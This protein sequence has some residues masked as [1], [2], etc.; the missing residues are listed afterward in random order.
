MN[1]RHLRIFVA[2]CETGSFTR[3]ATRLQMSQPALSKIV[4]DLEEQYSLRLFTRTGRGVRLTEG[5]QL[6]HKRATA[7]LREFDLLEEELLKVQDE[8]VGDVN[9]SIPHRVGR[10]I[11]LPL[12]KRFTARF[13]RASIHVFENLNIDTQHMIVCG[14]VDIG[15]FYL[16]PK[17]PSVAVEKI[18]AEHLYVVGAADIIGENNPITMAEASRLPLILPGARAHYRGFINNAF[19]AASYVPNVVRELE[20]V[21][22]LL[23]FAMEGEGATILPYSNIREE[24]ESKLMNARRLI[25]PAIRREVCMA[26]RNQASS[27]LIRDAA[28]LLKEVASE[29]CEQARWMYS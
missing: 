9:V 16:P 20:T 24:V 8:A 23:A 18:G 29:H 28:S 6:F 25:E 27:K 15:L 13:P 11:M 22:G 14:D 17:P 26:V 21:H 4:R 19:S 2:A 1:L 3:A 5:G 12:V 7:I 10:F